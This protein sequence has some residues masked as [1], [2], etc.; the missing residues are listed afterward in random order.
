M[1][2]L[3]VDN[4]T[5]ICCFVHW[6]LLKIPDSFERVPNKDVIDDWLYKKDSWGAGL[7][8]EQWAVDVVDECWKS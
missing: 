4:K 5:K 1:K 7:N 2:M 3:Y 6:L 8:A